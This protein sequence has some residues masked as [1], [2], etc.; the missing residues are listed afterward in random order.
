MVRR[1]ERQCDRKIA[2]YRT[3]VSCLFSLLLLFSFPFLIFLPIFLPPST[4][5]SLRSS[6]RLH[7]Q[8]EIE[9]LG[10]DTTTVDFASWFREYIARA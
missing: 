10:I 5:C 2:I 1:R 3:C 7:P 4:I 6:S 8:A 9:K